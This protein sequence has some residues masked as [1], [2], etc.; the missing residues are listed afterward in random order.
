MS[1]QTIGSK[2]V[3]VQNNYISN[4]RLFEIRTRIQGKK[5]TTMIQLIGTTETDS[6]SC[7]T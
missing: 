2:I 4:A 6:I 5:K 3:T 1:A 7:P